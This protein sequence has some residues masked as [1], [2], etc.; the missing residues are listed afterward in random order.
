MVIGTLE[1][2]RFA[3][4]QYLPGLP[5][6]LEGAVTASALIWLTTRKC[7]EK[8]FSDNVLYLPDQHE[9]IGLT[10]GCID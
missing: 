3:F 1:G 10:V 2:I 4:F 5:T 9:T 7:M 8:L 6:R